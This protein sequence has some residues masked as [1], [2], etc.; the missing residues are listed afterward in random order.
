MTS[1]KP[2]LSWGHSRMVFHLGRIWLWRSS[3]RF[4]SRGPGIPPG[5]TC[6]RRTHDFRPAQ[7]LVLIEA[8]DMI[9]PISLYTRNLSFSS[10]GQENC[11]S[12][13][14][15]CGFERMQRR[16]NLVGLNVLRSCRKA[17]ISQC[18]R[19]SL[20]IKYFAMKRFHGSFAET[21]PARVLMTFA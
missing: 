11:T 10:F 2:A 9:P 21:A 6:G 15:H 16:L 5:S 14:S 3:R 17:S 1:D 20:L 7:W 19:R 18:T 13:D 4:L 8:V 12:G